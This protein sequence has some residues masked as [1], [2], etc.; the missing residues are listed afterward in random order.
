MRFQVLAGRYELRR[1]IGR[2]GMAQVW[3][4]R[5]ARLGRRVAVKTVDLATA[6]DRALG[7]RLRREA[8]AVAGL[9]HPDIVTV[10]DTGVEGETAYLVMELIDGGDLAAALRQGP[11]P[12]S[13]ALRVAG[14][15]A[16]ALAAAHAAGIV[17]RD[18]KPANV[19]LHGDDVT[20]VDF[21]IAA[22]TQ[23]A[24]AAL[25]QPGTVVGTAQYMAPEQGEGGEVSPASDVYA[26]GCLLTAM[27]AGRP[28]FTGAHPLE[29]L[30]QHAAASPPR[31]A[32]LAAD[33]PHE[34]DDLV[35]AMLAK[36]PAERPSA[37]A[38]ARALEDL[39]ARL[40]AA[41]SLTP[42]A[43]T[44]VMPATGAT[45]AFRH[46]GGGADRPR[47][48][49]PGAPAGEERAS[50]GAA[51]SGRGWVAG[52]A[53]LA[54]LG[55]VAT[56]AV[57]LGGGE[58]AGNAPSADGAPPA[59]TAAP[60]SEPPATPAPEAA[61]PSPGPAEEPPRGRTGPVT[62]QG[63]PA[64]LAS[65]RTDDE[66]RDDLQ[67]QWD[68]VAE[69]LEKGKADKAADKASDLEKQVEELTREGSLSQADADALLD[70][71]TATLGA[72]VQD[73]GDDQQGDEKGADDGDRDRDG[74]GK[75]GGR[76]KD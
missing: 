70:E 12:V 49:A 15:V 17:H 11:L 8:V 18:V 27:V 53:A 47:A 9:R 73:A 76:G 7:E 55:G 16:G 39:R 29:V 63:V 64:L 37:A 32:T 13:E 28:P 21:G 43:A 60:T 44:E 41:A 31:L 52:V 62:G 59:A 69:A 51:R 36:R 50:P 24:G 71:V 10:H 14:R 46:D 4:A 2:G 30:R 3:E 25:T 54:V 19:L 57:L 72:E 42:T 22:A 75:D 58:P 23:A 56:S 26:L 45:R 65:L 35:A 40:P 67:E 34:L 61:R 74:G 68:K 20:V 6:D 48:A 1:L 66:T 5:D 33:V 38:A